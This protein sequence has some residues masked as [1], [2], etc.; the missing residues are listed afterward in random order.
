MGKFDRL[1]PQGPAVRLQ[2]DTEA[3]LASSDDKLPY[4]SISKRMQFPS[5]ANDS[6]GSEDQPQN[7]T[8]HMEEGGLVSM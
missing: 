4:S 7:S 8:D 6:F 5:F 1:G 3:S 2:Q